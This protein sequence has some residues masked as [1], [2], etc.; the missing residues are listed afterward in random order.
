MII[1]KAIVS[2]LL[3]MAAVLIGGLGYLFGVPWVP[4]EQQFPSPGP[5]LLLVVAIVITV[6]AIRV[7]WEIT[8]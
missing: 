7:A 2:V 6:T 3:L 4:W 5:V 1:V 8:E